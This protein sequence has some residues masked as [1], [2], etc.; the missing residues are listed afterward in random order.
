[1]GSR[2]QAD[3]RKKS[4]SFANLGLSEALVRAVADAGYTQATPIQLQA[5]PAILGGADL[6]GG[7]QT[8]TGK[9]AAFVL[10]ILQRLT[11][12]PGPAP[13]EARAGSRAA[14]RK[15]RAL[16]LA[17]TRELAA[18]ILESVKTYG[19]HSACTSSSVFGGVSIRPQIEELRRG[20]DILVATPG[21]LLDHVGQKTVDL[22]GVEVLVLDEADRML[23]M[24]FLPD[25][26]RV[27][28]TLPRQRQNLLFSAT[29][30]DEVGNLA[31]S[32]LKDPVQIQVTPRNTTVEKV[33][34]VVHPVDAARKAELLIHLVKE[35]NWF[36]VLVFTRTKHGANK[37]ALRLDKSGVPA[38]AIH[39]NKSQNART[40]ALAEFKTGS[41][42]VLVATDIAA[43]G[44][45]IDHLPHVVNF[46]LPN[47]PE[48]YVHR[49]G[50]TG[51]AGASGEAIS[52]VS[53]EENTLLKDI[54]RVTRQTLARRMVPGFEPGSAPSAEHAKADAD[55]DASVSARRGAP[56]RRGAPRSQGP[57]TSQ[58]G[59][60]GS[61]GRSQPRSARAADGTSPARPESQAA[62]TPRPA[63]AARHERAHQPA[64][65]SDARATPGA[66]RAAERTR[67]ARPAHARPRT[68]ESNLVRNNL[69]PGWG[70][71]PA[72]R[73]GR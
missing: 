51:R 33:A 55:A 37:L 61:Q 1:M 44:L 42:Q 13:A 2:R 62:T 43:R 7:A 48:D 34:Q 56:G 40:R 58:R 46:D 54:E 71:T 20:V 26:R 6:M 38:L 22:S 16:I 73:R 60:S 12:T 27:L 9:T 35:G 14:P 67:E 8:G 4:M 24:G 59:A 66:P 10:P 18:Q 21:R 47:V 45:D 53:R 15:V 64:T 19:K 57:R 63:P 23:D 41:L 11:T 36:Q 50:R 5:I 17:P 65:R 3:P 72:P 52:L 32:L 29:F 49:I 39:G 31:R 68:E 28:A 69:P 30:A 70:G 25:I